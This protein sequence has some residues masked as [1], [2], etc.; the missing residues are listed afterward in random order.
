MPRSGA[1]FRQIEGRLTS[2]VS[3][4]GATTTAVTRLVCRREG[5]IREGSKKGTKTEK[6]ETTKDGIKIQSLLFPRERLPRT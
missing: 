6:R 5:T 2:V 3:P 1:G 4:R